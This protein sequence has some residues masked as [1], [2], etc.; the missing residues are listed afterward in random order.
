MEGGTHRIAHHVRLKGNHYRTDPR[1]AFDNFDAEMRV[2]WDLF[3]EELEDPFKN[4]AIVHV[5]Q[6]G[7]T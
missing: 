3:L 1:L 6:P 7:D 4:G 5:L 2:E